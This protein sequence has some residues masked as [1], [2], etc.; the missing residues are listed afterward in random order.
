M[1]VKRV[2]RSKV[3][4]NPL[5]H[6]KQLAK[7]ISHSSRLSLKQKAEMLKRI[8]HFEHVHKKK[9]SRFLKSKR[10]SYKYSQDKYLPR[11]K[12]HLVFPS[13]LAELRAAIVERMK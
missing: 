4:Y 10:K 9:P 3:S 5:A 6:E 2:P 8:S 12:Q 11:K 13:R 1:P 7:A